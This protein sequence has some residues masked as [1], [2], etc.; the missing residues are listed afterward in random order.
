MTRVL[1]AFVQEARAP[2]EELRDVE[3]YY[4]MCLGLSGLYDIT[5]TFKQE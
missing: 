3:T 5:H 1:G 2:Q 4:V